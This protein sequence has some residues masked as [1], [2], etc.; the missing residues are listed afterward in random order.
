MCLGDKIDIASA[1]FVDIYTKIEVNE[2]KPHSWE[3][4]HRLNSDIIPN[5]PTF[6]GKDQGDALLNFVKR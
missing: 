6:I 5:K 4:W 2:K 3:L 1:P